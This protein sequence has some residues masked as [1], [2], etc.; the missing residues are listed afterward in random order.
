MQS[1]DL[2]LLNPWLRNIRDVYRLGFRHPQ[3]GTDRPGNRP[4]PHH[5]RYPGNIP[6]DV[7]L[8]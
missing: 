5:G 2:G 6:A 7:N 1:A 8:R 3:R 4:R